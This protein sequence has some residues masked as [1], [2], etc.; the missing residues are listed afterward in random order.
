MRVLVV[1]DERPLAET[2]RRGLAAEGFVVDVAHDGIDGLATPAT[3]S[4]TSSSSTSCCPGS[5]A[6]RSSGGC[7]A[8]G[9]GRRC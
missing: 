4:T 5:T 1:D 7:A 8:A 2:L 6:T 9:S 3:A